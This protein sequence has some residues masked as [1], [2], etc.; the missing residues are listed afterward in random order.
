M[1]N[2]LMHSRDTRGF[3]LIELLIVIAIIGILTA[4]AIPAF[5]GQREK[6]KVRSTETGAKAAISDLQGYLDA[7]VFGEPYV[8]ITDSS[9]AQGCFEADNAIGTNK[10]CLAAFN[11]ASVGTYAT[12]PGGLTTVISHFISHHTFKGDK[13]AFNGLPLFVTTS[14]TDGQV[15]LSPS[16][17]RSVFILAY[18]ANTTSPILSQLVSIR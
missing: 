8:I 6:A 7:Y 13:S 9:G 18:A 16:G 14:A 10:A 1:M 4:I 3:T 5:V 11:Q 15:L 2:K 17:S 12:Y